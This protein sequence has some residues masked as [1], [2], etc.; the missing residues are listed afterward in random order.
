MTSRVD[1]KSVVIGGLSVAVISLLIA[2]TAEAPAEAVGRY[3]LVTAPGTVYLVDS[4]TGQV[5]SAGSGLARDSDR[6]FKLPKRPGTVSRPPVPRVGAE[7]ETP[8][9]V[10]EPPATVQAPRPAVPPGPADF[11]GN[12]VLT[13]P[14]EEQLGIRIEEGGRSVLTEGSNMWEGRWRLE[15]GRIII[16][17]E[18]ETVTG[19]LDAQGRLLVREGAGEP[20]AFE[21]AR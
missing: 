8:A 12:W 9:V 7:V 4:V 13:H 16:S 1:M 6:D 19:R 2:A 5:W 20:I 14:T 18:N 11:I 17:T 15:D 3:Q 10:P 21:K